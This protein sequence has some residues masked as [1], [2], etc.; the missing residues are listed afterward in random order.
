MVHCFHQQEAAFPVRAKEVV[1]LN[2]KE[3]ILTIRLSRKLSKHPLYAGVLGVECARLRVSAD[4]AK[5][6]Q[7]AEASRN[8]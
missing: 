6:S 7:T 8:Q 1:L 2:A 5:L 4:A 3:R